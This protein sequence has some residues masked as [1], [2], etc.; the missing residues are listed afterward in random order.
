[1]ISNTKKAA[2]QCKLVHHSQL[3]DYAVLRIFFRHFRG[4]GAVGLRCRRFGEDSSDIVCFNA[5]ANAPGDLSLFLHLRDG[6]CQS[7]ICDR[8]WFVRG[9]HG[10]QL[11]LHVCKCAIG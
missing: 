9:K 11:K 7:I 6:F 1:M 10:L 4:D 8:E 2:N 5:L 3:A